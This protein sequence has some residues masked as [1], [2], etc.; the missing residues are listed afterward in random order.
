MQ[1]EVRSAQSRDAALAYL[2]WLES[3]SDVGV[4]LS[5]GSSRLDL[6][7][8]EKLSDEEKALVV[9]ILESLPF[10]IS[11]LV[12]VARPG[13]SVCL[14]FTGQFQGPSVLFSGVLTDLMKS[15]ELKK[16]LWLNLRTFAEDQKLS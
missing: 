14:D 11:E 5:S 4:E 10:A 2:S 13:A 1:A 8:P 9:K 7:L 12:R 16:Q 3:L 15:P 6:I